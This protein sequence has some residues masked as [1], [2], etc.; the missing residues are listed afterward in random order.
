MRTIYSPVFT[1]PIE[2]IEIIIVVI[3]IIANV[4]SWCN[5]EIL[6]QTKAITNTTIEAKTFIGRIVILV[7]L[8]YHSRIIKGITILRERMIIPI[9]SHRATQLHL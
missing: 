5:R 1:Q 9:T 3:V 2:T 4:Q 7:A 8:I 6:C